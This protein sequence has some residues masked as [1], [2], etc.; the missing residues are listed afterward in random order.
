MLSLKYLFSLRTERNLV[1][2]ALVFF[3][4]VP[5]SVRSNCSVV[6]SNRES[7]KSLCFVKEICNSAVGL[8]I[9]CH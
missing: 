4:E 1:V 3:I 6:S 7:L 8:C 9:I 2:I 5:F